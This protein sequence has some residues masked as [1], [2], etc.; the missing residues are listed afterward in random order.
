MAY[1]SQDKKAKIKTALSKVV[2]KGWKYSLRVH[3]HTEIIM[4][5]SSAPLDLVAEARKND[6]PREYSDN[7]ASVNHFHYMAQFE[8][9][10][11][12][13]N[14]FGKII[15]A[16]N[17]DNF[18]KSDSQTD[19]FHVGHYVNLHLGRWDKDFVNTGKQS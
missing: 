2:P 15:D 14:T 7:H 6:K 16:L 18:D 12:L 13:Q 10:T 17:T 8:G 11:Y 3:N 9:N 1:V 4:T 19:Y 5:I